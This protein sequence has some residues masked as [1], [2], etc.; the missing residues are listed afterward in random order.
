LR[1]QD[2]PLRD[3]AVRIASST[4]PTKVIITQGHRGSLPYNRPPVP[5][6][7]TGGVDT[8]GAGD[9]FIA[10][11][12]PLISAGLHLEQAAFVGNVAG[13]MKTQIVGHR[14]HVRRADLIRTIEQLLS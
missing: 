13:G 4:A 12:A 1:D 8:M 6:F 3:I 2:A 9:A 10:V 7:F 11:T 14:D 5:A